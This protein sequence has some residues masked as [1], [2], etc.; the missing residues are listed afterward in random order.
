MIIKTPILKS[1]KITKD[2]RDKLLDL[3]EKDKDNPNPFSY[4]C[5]ISEIPGDNENFDLNCLFAVYD[6]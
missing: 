2:Q 3:V 1:I 4:D 6:E 5:V